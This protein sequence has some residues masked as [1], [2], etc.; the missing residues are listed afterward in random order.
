MAREVRK[1]DQNR[2]T[3]STDSGAM[4][5][6]GVFTREIHFDQLNQSISQLATRISRK[7]AD[8]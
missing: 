5:R 4:V 2:A 3:S 1:L 7:H 6:F 8:K